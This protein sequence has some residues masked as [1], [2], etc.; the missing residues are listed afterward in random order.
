MSTTDG[1]S[2]AIPR[3]RGPVSPVTMSE[4]RRTIALPEKDVD[5]R[6]GSDKLQ[7]AFRRA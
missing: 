7:R 6:F 1:T 4:P 2:N 3:W 5:Q